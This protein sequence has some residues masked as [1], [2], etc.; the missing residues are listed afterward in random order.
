MKTQKKES[1]IKKVGTWISPKKI[2]NKMKY[3][4]WTLNND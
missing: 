2:I 4:N 3:K 1:L